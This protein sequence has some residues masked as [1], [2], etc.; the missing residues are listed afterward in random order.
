MPIFKVLNNYKSVV[1]L[2]K[3]LKIFKNIYKYFKYYNI[4]ELLK[5]MFNKPGP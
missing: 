1:K 4:I 5:I 3:Q 2:E